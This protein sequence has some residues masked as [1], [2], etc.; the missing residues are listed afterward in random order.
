MSR[1]IRTLLIRDDGSFVWRIR[2][3]RLATL[4]EIEQFGVTTPSLASRSFADSLVGP[5]LRFACV[6]SCP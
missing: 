2:F 6:L 5:A 3:A 1:L 4:E